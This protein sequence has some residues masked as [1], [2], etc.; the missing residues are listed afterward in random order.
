MS[1]ERKNDLSESEIAVRVA[2]REAAIDRIQQT[3]QRERTQ[4]V[5]GALGGTAGLI[6]GLIAA[7]MLENI[8]VATLGFAVMAIGYG[9][10][11]PAQLVKLV[12]RNGS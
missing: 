2:E 12:R 7:L 8:A 9:L 11:T 1:D 10:V 4:T 3:E 5:G 6:V